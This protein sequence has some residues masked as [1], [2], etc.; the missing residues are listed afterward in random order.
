MFDF[1]YNMWLMVHILIVTKI[2]CPFEL[3]ILTKH[4]SD[5]KM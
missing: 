5:S 3:V 4:T 2:Y 1:M